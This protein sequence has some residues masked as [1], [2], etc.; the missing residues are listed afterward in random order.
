MQA[1][2][3]RCRELEI[4]QARYRADLKAYIDATARLEPCPLEDWDQALVY[5]D[6]ARAAF[7]NAR[8]VLN[9]HI[10]GHGCDDQSDAQ[11]TLLDE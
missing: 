7:G 4:L 6:R 11:R 10:A 3:A 1:A 2:P 5:A 9:I 8:A